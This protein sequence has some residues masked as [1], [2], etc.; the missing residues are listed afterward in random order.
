MYYSGYCISSLNGDVTKYIQ[1][2]E[3]H[4]L[5]QARKEK[6]V[7]LYYNIKASI[8]FSLENAKKGYYDFYYDN[9]QPFQTEICILYALNRLLEKYHKDPASFKLDEYIKLVGDISNIPSNTRKYPSSLMYELGCI[10]DTYNTLLSQIR[11]YSITKRLS[12][13][14]SSEPIEESL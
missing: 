3:Q 14:A 2:F 13:T 8:Q 12:F 5:T 11:L 4:P 1:S 9:N 7:Y 10:T 6:S